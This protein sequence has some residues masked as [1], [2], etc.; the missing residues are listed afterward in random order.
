MK[1]EELCQLLLKKENGAL[2]FKRK[3]HSVFNE[4]NILAERNQ[5]TLILDVVALANG[6]P[7]VVGETAYLIFGADDK[8]NEDGSRKL[9]DTGD[10]QL[11]RRQL[12][13]WIN[14][15]VSPRITELECEVVTIEGAKL[16]VITIYPSEN[17]HITTAKLQTADRKQYSAQTTFIR[18]NE[19]NEPASRE[20]EETLRK[21]KRRYFEHSSYVNPIWACAF[22]MGLTAFV[23]YLAMGERLLTEDM[24]LY[25]DS[26][27]AHIFSTLL[28][29]TVFIF[30]G[31][32]LGKV[33]VD[34]KEMQIL[35]IQ[36][37]KQRRLLMLATGIFVVLL[38]LSIYRLLG[39]I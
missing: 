15:K 16:F 33:V 8:Q 29:T 11:S 19:N 17:V 20:E 30:S 22:S 21:A 36:G 12:L 27:T 3:P 18:V 14:A 6:N 25:M 32:M 38:I 2:D 31:W 4:D 26:H 13:D 28:A 9:Y 34:F 7:H 1:E 5:H 39:L 23:I 37:T 10:F 24:L 35:W